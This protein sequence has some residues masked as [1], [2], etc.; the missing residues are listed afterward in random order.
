MKRFNHLILLAFIINPLTACD[1]AEREAPDQRAAD[2]A[3]QASVP[4]ESAAPI[5]KVAS[6][7]R[8]PQDF[9]KAWAEIKAQ[10]DPT[11]RLKQERALKGAWEKKRYVWSGVALAS[12]CQPERRACAVNV[13]RRR[14]DEHAGSVGGFFPSVSFS[15]QGWA[16]LAKGVRGGRRHARSRFA[17]SYRSSR[18]T[19]GARS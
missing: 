19:S 10:T 8:S 2:G 15:E 14:G 9:T 17:P 7:D 18:R 11:Q 5:A 6:S 16:T 13:F 1:R 12:L 3:E 4:S